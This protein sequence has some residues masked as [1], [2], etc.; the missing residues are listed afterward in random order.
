MTAIPT[1]DGFLIPSE[2]KPESRDTAER[3]ELDSLYEPL[4]VHSTDDPFNYFA[5]GYVSVQ[6]AHYYPEGLREIRKRH[7]GR[8]GKIRV[9]LSPEGSPPDLWSFVDLT[10]EQATALSKNLRT[11]VK[12]ASKIRAIRDRIR[13]AKNPIRQHINARKQ[14]AP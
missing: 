3:R 14:T 1:D 5:D 10:A 9:S 8:V 13:D 7:Y 11:V 12:N 4:F 2:P 6:V